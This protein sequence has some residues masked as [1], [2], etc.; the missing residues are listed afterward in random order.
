MFEKFKNFYFNL[1][2]RLD[3]RIRWSDLRNHRIENT[4]LH[5]LG[6]VEGYSQLAFWL[7]LPVIVF[8][9]YG[10]L[11]WRGWPLL[12]LCLLAIAA[13][14]LICRFARGRWL[15]R[16]V[17]VLMGI[18]AASPFLLA[19]GGEG[20]QHDA[21]PYAHIFG[22]FGFLVL[23]IGMPASRWWAD[24]LIGKD[25]HWFRR[26]FAGH[27]RETQLFVKP[28]D[29]SRPGSA[30]P[31]KPPEKRGIRVLRSY[32]LVPISSILMLTVVPAI[33]VLLVDKSLVPI[34]TL[35]SVAV[36]WLLLSFAHYHDRLNTFQMLVRE[37]LLS[38]GTAIVS[39]AVII[40]AVTRLFNV[41]YVTTV[42]D[43]SS[44]WTVVEI[45]LILYLIFWL[46]DYWR[47][48][49]AAEVLLG[50]LHEE[51]SE[52]P[53]SIAYP[54]KEGATLSI[55]GAGRLI[56][57]CPDPNKG[58]ESYR[59][60]EVF[61]KIVNQLECRARTDK[62]LWKK[63][64]EASEAFDA[65]REKGRLYNVIPGIVI[66][67]LVG[68]G[69]VWVNGLEQRPGL[70][71][72]SAD[73]GS[74][75]LGE[76]LREAPA[77]QTVFAVAASGGGTRAA[78][79]SYSVLRALHE[80]GALDRVVLL[81]SVSGGSAG[82]AYFAAHRQSLLDHPVS[83]EVW[84]DYRDAL[85]GEHIK[86]V[87]A[88]VGEW[89]F[90]KGERLGKLLIESFD[91]AF[92]P[93]GCGT[94]GCADVGVIFN[95]AVTGAWRPDKRNSE[96]CLAD[97]RKQRNCATK[98]R[99][100]SRLVVTNVDAMT[101]D[102]AQ[103]ALAGW[104]LDFDY[105]VVRDPQAPLTAAASM[106]ANFP[107]VFSNT[108]VQIDAGSGG[109]ARRYWVT[110]GGA[111]E[112]RGV[113]SLLLA[114]LAEAKNW[115]SDSPPPPSIRI[116]VADASGTSIAYSEDRGIGAA[117]A[118]KRQ[119]ADRLI[120]E[121]GH[122][123]KTEWQRLS[124]GR[125][126]AELVHLPMPEVFRSGIGTH[127]QLPSHVSLSDPEG[128]YRTSKLKFWS[129]PQTIDLDEGGILEVFHLLFAEERD[130]EQVDGTLWEWAAA[131]EHGDPRCEL[132]AAMGKS[133]TKCG[134]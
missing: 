94:I 56:A 25:K 50:L 34:A 33:C 7:P 84:G 102:S 126:T 116:L 4:W 122:E 61:R 86:R 89:R 97:R 130:S 73:Q 24:L 49:A 101:G 35:V 46:F 8:F 90:L 59:P 104:P 117:A 18:V 42:L 121:L 85:A 113:V 129:R 76:R 21:L 109:Q 128:W 118:A 20:R 110:D 26:V 69:V 53:T 40:F 70:K 28:L 31:A 47:D 57:A 77:G 119:I 88:G 19:P 44:R 134:R 27:L 23:T 71:A 127:W 98:D 107:P 66:A 74:F 65:L 48:R 16:L 29:P 11:N 5:R 38:G 112:N 80:A 72:V 87:L 39:L 10:L 1:P 2:F 78:L 60:L 99:T 82:V 120:G 62:A 12:V 91:D 54:R 103:L 64:D 100:G 63:V 3:Q 41:G 68:A 17:W 93:A 81:S 123:V 106:S 92:L 75:D 45:I 79:Y 114:L 13:H 30:D 125:S 9:A 131:G 124:G 58:F 14:V 43:Q 37:A 51:G 111:V 55:H 132:F 52:H 108:A 36:W 22:F 83:H 6:F 133:S 95:T 96:A 32:L 67:A 105:E 115:P 15:P